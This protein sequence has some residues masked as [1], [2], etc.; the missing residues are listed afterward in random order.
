[1]NKLTEQLVNKFEFA[2]K[3]NEPS[4]IN[5]LSSLVKRSRLACIRN[6]N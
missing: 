1:M 5:K 3:I 6:K 4:L 2:G